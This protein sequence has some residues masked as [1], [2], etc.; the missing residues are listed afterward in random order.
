MTILRL[1]HL[2]II[3]ILLNACTGNQQNNSTEKAQNGFV[4]SSQAPATGDG[5]DFCRKL[6][7]D[8]VVINADPANTNRRLF[9]MSGGGVYKV[10]ADFGNIVASFAL[11]QSGENIS[12][13]TSDNH[14]ECLSNR[15]CFTISE[16]GNILKYNNQQHIFFA[17]SFEKQDNSTLIVIE[18][19]NNTYYGITVR[20]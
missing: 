19:P 11:Q 15:K 20:K 8:A 1:L 2:L 9:L 6:L 17:V 14:P 5:N 7:P 3:S 13:F 10:T 18:Y 4:F 16:S 12:V